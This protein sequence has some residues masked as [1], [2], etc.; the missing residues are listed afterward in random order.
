MAYQRLIKEFNLKQDE[1]AE[2]V[3]KSRT[4]I[5]NSMRLLKLCPAVQSMLIEEMLSSGHARAIIPIEDSEQQEM[6]ANKIFDEKLS[7]RET[8][9]LVRKLLKDETK[10]K[11]KVEK[12][13][14]DI[15]YRDLEEKMKELIGTKVS[16]QKKSKKKGVIGI[17]YYSEEELERILGLLMTIQK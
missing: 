10:P 11:K 14:N 16:I 2:R 7:V 3:A 9:K 13:K 6:L 12:D 1:L 15:F 4:A 8:E 5:T 17:E